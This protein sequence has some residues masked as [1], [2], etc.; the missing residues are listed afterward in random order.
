MSNCN[1]KKIMGNIITFDKLLCTVQ[2]PDVKDKND[3]IETLF[4]IFV[5]K[6]K[7]IVPDAKKKNIILAA[8][9]IAAGHASGITLLDLINKGTSSECTKTHSVE[10]E[11]EQEETSNKEPKLSKEDLDALSE[12]LKSIFGDKTSIKIFTSDDKKEE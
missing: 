11:K 5:G 12:H 1:C 7:E 9:Y 6:I 2:K 8:G 3:A 4:E 10:E